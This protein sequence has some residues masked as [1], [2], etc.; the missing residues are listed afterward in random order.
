MASLND[1]RQAAGEFSA[2]RTE[3]VSTQEV[4]THK[5]T[6]RLHGSSGRSAWRLG[7]VSTNQTSPWPTSRLWNRNK[8]TGRKK[9]NERITQKPENGLER[10]RFKEAS[11]NKSFQM[12]T[13]VAN[14]CLCL[15]IDCKRVWQDYSLNELPSV[16]ATS[17]A[18]R[19]VCVFLWRECVAKSTTLFWAAI[20]SWSKFKGLTN[21]WFKKKKKNARALHSLSHTAWYELCSLRQSSVLSVCCLKRSLEDD[22]RAPQ[23]TMFIMR[24]WRTVQEEEP[25]PDVL[26]LFSC[27]WQWQQNCSGRIWKT[28]SGK[29]KK[30]E[31]GA[32]KHFGEKLAT[33]CENDFLLSDTCEEKSSPAGCLVRTVWWEGGRAGTRQGPRWAQLSSP[34]LTAGSRNSGPDPQ[35]FFARQQKHRQVFF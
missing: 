20:S 22:W 14:C 11:Y 30:K 3:E 27:I 35:V 8:K 17:T 16:V 24:L 7:S 4:L 10:N 28:H 33:I 9:K 2:V 31:R 13:S 25:K 18:L 32:G 5:A 6:V 34:D 23:G 19:S 1:M 15:R 21:Q 29:K 12:H 26:A